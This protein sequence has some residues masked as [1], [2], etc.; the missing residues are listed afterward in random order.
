MLTYLPVLKNSKNQFGMEI[1]I[2]K[3][4]KKNQRT[5]LRTTS[6]FMK[7]IDSSKFFKK[8]KNKHAINKSIKFGFIYLGF[9]NL[10]I[11]FCPYKF[12]CYVGATQF[13][14]EKVANESGNTK[15]GVITYLFANKV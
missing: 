2:L 11:I 4:G 5:G 7:T 1:T 12:E 13:V 10:M 6:Y 8:T 9:V 3:K 14:Y 15:Y